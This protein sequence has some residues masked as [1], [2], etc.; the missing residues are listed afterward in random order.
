MSKGEEIIRKLQD[1]EA[2]HK[3]EW[4]G[5]TEESE[6]ISDAVVFIKSLLKEL[7]NCR[8]ELCLRCGQYKQAHLGACDGCRYKDM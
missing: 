3:K 5:A 6:A 1:I 7:Q 2:E 4:G 8:D